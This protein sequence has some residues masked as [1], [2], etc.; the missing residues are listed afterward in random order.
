M[1]HERLPCGLRRSSEE[2]VIDLNHILLDCHELQ[3]HYGTPRGDQA[4]PYYT[5]LP[6]YLLKQVP[7]RKLANLSN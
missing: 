1:K 4:D 2:I 3:Q 5:C 6:R 7:F